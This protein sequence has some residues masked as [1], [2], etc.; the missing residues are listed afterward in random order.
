M[1]GRQLALDLSPRRTAV[2]YMRSST[3]KQKH[4]IELQRIQISEWAA[5]ENVSVVS[6][7][8]DVGVSGAKRMSNRPGMTEA[9]NFL[10]A[11]GAQFLV[12]S[13]A[14]RLA[15]NVDAANEIEAEAE[16]LGA[17][18]L[19]IEQIDLTGAYG[20]LVHGLSRALADYRR[21]ILQNG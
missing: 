11:T 1:N 15:R 4:S 3:L 18:V 6:W 17:S 14:D 2:A 8:E 7:H 10:S 12:V 20:D 19:Y 5:R 16:R 9:L 13:H 21:A